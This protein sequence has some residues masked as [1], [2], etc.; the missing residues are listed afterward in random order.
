M[1][2][3]EPIENLQDVNDEDA[4]AEEFCDLKVLE[5][6]IVHI[7]GDIFRLEILEAPM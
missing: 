3:R 5:N 4:G 7:M 2:A 1:L 6:Y